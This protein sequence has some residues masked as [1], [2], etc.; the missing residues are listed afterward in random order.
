MTV[1]P[2]TEARGGEVDA[3]SLEAALRAAVTGEVRF[4]LG[5]RAAYSTDASNYRQ[6]PICVVVPRS[7]DDVVAT[8]STCREHGAP[9]LSR[10]G[11]TSLA[12][13]SCNVAVVVD[14]SKYVNQILEINAKEHFARVRPGVVLDHLRAAAKPHGLTY[15]PDPST[16]AWCTLG[17]MIGNNSCGTHS[18]MAGKTVDNVEELEILTYDGLRMRVGWMSREDVASKAQVPGRVG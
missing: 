16:H 11:G 5:S 8:V 14:W 1:G 12:G 3:A 9:V 7:I 10:G 2:R 17:G 18:Q 13:Q 15:G 4:D 6:V